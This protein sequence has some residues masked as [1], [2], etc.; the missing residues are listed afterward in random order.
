MKI[1]E[2]AALF[3]GI[4]TC[5]TGLIYGAR[6]LGAVGQLTL[7]SGSALASYAIKV[8]DGASW[9]LP[10]AKSALGLGIIAAR[11]AGQNPCCSKTRKC[12]SFLLAG[13]SA[14]VGGLTPLLPAKMGLLVGQVNQGLFALSL[15]VNGKY[16]H[17]ELIP[18]HPGLFL[19]S[20]TEIA[21][22]GLLPAFP[23]SQ[24]AEPLLGLGGMATCAL[25][26]QP[27]QGESTP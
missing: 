22:V 1:E 3:A 18:T 7:P 16:Y 2:A 19:I 13:V 5:S 8:T 4:A 6:Q 14:L 26:R 12:E 11:I 9:L 24:W 27:A 15:P 21:R 25:V 17:N 23:G 20:I 10:I